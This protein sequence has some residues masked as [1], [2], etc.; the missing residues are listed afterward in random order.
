M[1]LS[2]L[3]VEDDPN[4]SRLLEIYLSKTFDITRVGTAQGAAGAIA[5]GTFDV[6]LLDVMLPDRPGWDLLHLLQD[7]HPATKIL[8]M[9]GRTDD[10]TQQEALAMGAHGVLTKPI[11]PA[12]VKTAIDALR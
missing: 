1:A 8:V 9:T 10:E 3:L 5:R 6:V 2:I 4:I 7:E 12:D 11:T